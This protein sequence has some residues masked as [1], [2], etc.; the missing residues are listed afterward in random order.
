[1]NFIKDVTKI[2]LKTLKRESLIKIDELKYK[3]KHNLKTE[4]QQD[5][6]NKFNKNFNKNI[7][8]IF[9]RVEQVEPMATNIVSSFD[10]KEDKNKNTDNKN[11]DNKNTDN[12]NK[13]NKNKDIEDRKK[14]ALF[15]IN[16]EK[17]KELV[18]QQQKENEEKELQKYQFIINENN[19]IDRNE[20]HSVYRII[21]I[22]LICVAIVLI[23]SIKS[24]N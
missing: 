8:N 13:D 5:F 16:F 1:M 24:I 18:K 21:G 9:R 12:K 4:L 19:N 20:N 11:T 23:L 10:N 3:V 14:E 6:N 17:Y 15:N 22:V 7:D 2:I